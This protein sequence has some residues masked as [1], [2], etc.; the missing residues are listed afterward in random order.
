VSLLSDLQTA[1]LREYARNGGGLL[2]TFE[3]GRYDASGAR[4]NDLALGDVFH[5]AAA[6]DIE[7]PKGNSYYARI[8]DRHVV[9]AGFEDTSVLPGAEYRLPVKTRLPQALTVVRPYPAF[10]PEEAYPRQA[11]TD[12]PAIVITEEG[13]SRRI[14][15][16]G[17]IERTF[18][19]TGNGDLSRILQQAIR[20]L[21]RDRMAVRVT[22]DGPVELFARG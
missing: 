21:A 2:A 15:L 13:M 10:P 5:V 3:T 1:A 17:D 16:P 9:L 12:E 6:G 11:K 14:W 18:W 8:E 19:K 20:W 22:G 4:R 7:G